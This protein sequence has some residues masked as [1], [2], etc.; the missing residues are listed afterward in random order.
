MADYEKSSSLFKVLGDPIRL[1][2][3]DMLSCGELCACD[4]LENLS[5]TQPTLSHHM[6]I[7]INAELVRSERRATWAFYSLNQEKISQ[8]H[9]I[10]EELTQPGDGCV[11]L[12]ESSPCQC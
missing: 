9:Q 5:I 10:L 4:I 8:L 2:I 1:H 12:K 6:K 11:C 3:L 7:L